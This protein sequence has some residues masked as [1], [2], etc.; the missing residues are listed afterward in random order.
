M[1]ELIKT[2]IVTDHDNDLWMI[3]ID[4]DMILKLLDKLNNICPLDLFLAPLMRQV[5]AVFNPTPDD[6]PEYF[7][8]FNVRTKVFSESATM[9]SPY[10]IE[11]SRE[12]RCSRWVPI[13]HSGFH[14]YLW[15]YLEKETDHDF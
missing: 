2:L 14:D 9:P 1:E 13:H 3:Q 11:G 12:I 4:M 7:F 10:R 8:W 15:K 5:G 6:I